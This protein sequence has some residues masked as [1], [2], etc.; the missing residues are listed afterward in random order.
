[1]NEAQKA[2][3]SSFP[4]ADRGLFGDDDDE[5]DQTAPELVGAQEDFVEAAKLKAKLKQKAM[6]EK[7]LA[8]EEDDEDATQKRV[9]FVDDVEVGSEE[10]EDFDAM[11]SEEMVY[12]SEEEDHA[13]REYQKKKLKEE[14]AKKGIN[15]E[16]LKTADDFYD[17]AKE[18]KKVQKFKPADGV[19]FT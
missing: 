10:D 14:M 15:T 4:A 9:R 7:K 13:E 3:L 1:M 19:K 6:R 18:V 12:D 16:E 8:R 2:L 17:V 11:D 5:D